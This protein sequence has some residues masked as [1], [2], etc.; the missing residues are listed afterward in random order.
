MIGRSL[1]GDTIASPKTDDVAPRGC[2][3]ARVSSQDDTAG[4]VA[5]VFDAVADVYDQSGVAFFE[6]IAHGLVD[7][8]RPAPG[9]HVVDIGCGRGAVTFPVARA[10]GPTGRVTAVDIAPAMVEHTRRRAEELGCSQVRTAL[11]ADGDLGLPDHSADVVA[12]S[13]VLFFAPDPAA[14]LRSWLRLLVPGGR[15]GITTFGVADP[16]WKQIDDLFRPY[17]PAAMLDARTT[18]AAG[19]FNSDR[20]VEDLMTS[21]GATEV[22]TERRQLPVHFADAEQWRRFST[23]TGQRAM[24]GF[25]PEDHRETLFEQAAVILEHNRTDA[26]DIV[27]LQDLRYTLATNA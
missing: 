26:G 15:I 10:V 4:R 12:S 11:V 22:R 1:L 17:L 5:R 2:H 3:H 23:G 6:P 8:L 14:T 9:E 20:G 25:V 21:C 19:A 13:L 24:W 16:T 7:L 27:L 18:G